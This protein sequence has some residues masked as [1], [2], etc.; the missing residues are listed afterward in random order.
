MQTWKG[1]TCLIIIQ[2]IYLESI[3]LFMY[4]LVGTLIYLLYLI[5]SQ[6]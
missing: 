6:H 2:Y 1:F 5:M 3:N 4:E